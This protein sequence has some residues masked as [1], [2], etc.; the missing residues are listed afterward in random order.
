[1]KKKDFCLITLIFV[2]IFSVIIVRKLTNLDEIWNY[3]F[4]RVMSDGL[5]PYRNISMITTPL[6]P[7]ITAFFL[8]VTIN[9][10]II[11]RI[12]SACLWT[13][14]FYTFYK[15]LLLITKDEKI[16]LIFMVIMGIT[17]KKI[18]YID[19][20]VLSLLFALIILYL[21][22][23]KID[24]KENL[25]KTSRKYNIAIRNFSRVDN[26]YKTNSRSN[27]IYNSSVI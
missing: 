4:A 2:S 9:E 24:K 7:M 27:D 16:S 6:L 18:F 22:L 13:G 17:C 12:L 1:M 15:N 10:I 26:L 5:I 11:S 25:L 8:K 21:E 14:I 23:R 19:Y 20:N 3:N